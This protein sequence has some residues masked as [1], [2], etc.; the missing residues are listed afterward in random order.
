MNDSNSRRGFLKSIFYSG[1]AI[2]LLP[3]LKIHQVFAATVNMADP[4]VK[5][6]GYVNKASESKDRKD[7]KAK[8]GN[9]QFYLSPGKPMAKCQLIPNG[10]VSAEG[11]CKSY[12]KRAEVKKDPKKTT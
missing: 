8:C 12:S 5:A 3:T 2:L 11:W 4:L 1:L 7:T 9:C 10:E 6:L